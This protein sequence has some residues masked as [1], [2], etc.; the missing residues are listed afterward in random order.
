MARARQVSTWHEQGFRAKSAEHFK[1]KIKSTNL[2]ERS[3][4]PIAQWWTDQ[5]LAYRKSHKRREIK[6]RKRRRVLSHTQN[7]FSLLAFCLSYY[8]THSLSHTLSPP[9]L[10][11]LSLTK[12]HI[13]YPFSCSSSVFLS[14]Y[15]NVGCVLCLPPR[16]GTT[17]VRKRLRQ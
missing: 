3:A 10:P 5:R 14:T 1:K 12:T 9:P 2:S 15:L 17:L 16:N 13:L 11:T 8:L 6:N 7:L 4:V